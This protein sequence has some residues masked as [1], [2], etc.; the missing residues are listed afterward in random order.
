[1][2]GYTN[3]RQAEAKIADLEDFQGANWRGTTDK[4]D[5]YFGQL[6]D[7]ALEDFRN[8]WSAGTLT[9]VVMSYSTPIAWVLEDGTKVVPEEWYSQT[10][11]R[12]QKAVRRAWKM[13][14]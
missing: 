9:Y 13:E 12:Q 4:T 3:Y 11:T 1:M 7:Q 5:V 2:S 10:T 14:V 8:A 6:E